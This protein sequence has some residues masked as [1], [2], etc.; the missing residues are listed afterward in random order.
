M[1]TSNEC[2]YSLS[3]DLSYTCQELRKFSKIML[4]EK[5]HDH[6]RGCW[7]RG[8]A[9]AFGVAAPCRPRRQRSLAR[10]HASLLSP[11]C[12]RHPAEVGFETLCRQK[13]ADQMTIGR[14]ITRRRLSYLRTAITPTT[15]FPT[16]L[17]GIPHVDASTWKSVRR[18]VAKR[19]DAQPRRVKNAAAFEVTPFVMR[20]QRRGLFSAAAWRSMGRWPRAAPAGRRPPKGCVDLAGLKNNVSKLCLT[21]PT[22]CPRQDTGFFESLPL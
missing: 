13:T 19:R 3:L 18:E 15:N 11:S 6:K 8:G 20:G 1:I 16:L 21:A 17:R 4:L 22:P 2:S 14:P 10:R 12:C 7:K 5:P 9:V